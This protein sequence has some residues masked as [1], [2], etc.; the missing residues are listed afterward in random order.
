MTTKHVRRA[1]PL[2]LL[3]VATAFTLLA[4]AGP[5][6]HATRGVVRAVTRSVL[7]VSRGRRG[8]MTFT[9]NDATYREGHIVVGTTVSIR[10]RD[11]GATHVATAIAV[12]QGTDR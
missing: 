9:M 1:C 3:I 4:A 12:Q 8:D 2:P 10:Y 6:I 7:V 11:Q 5:V